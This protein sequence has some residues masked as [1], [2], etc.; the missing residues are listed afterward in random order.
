M[1]N[2]DLKA[3]FDRLMAEKAETKKAL[4][5]IQAKVKAARN[6]LYDMS[7]EYDATAPEY[8]S[9]E[10]T[11]TDLEAQE[12]AVGKVYRKQNNLSLEV[13]NAWKA[14]CSPLSQ[15]KRS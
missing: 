13:L 15:L 11:L 14:S 8:Q 7:E 3:S 12:E 4:D 9:A 5:A 2:E 10:A 1:S 6:T